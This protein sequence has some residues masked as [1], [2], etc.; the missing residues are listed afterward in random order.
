MEVIYTDG[1][2]EEENGQRMGFESPLDQTPDRGENKRGVISESLKEVDGASEPKESLV[3]IQTTN[4]EQN[5][6]GPN[7]LTFA[8]SMP[9]AYDN[10]SVD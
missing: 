3:N 7:G 5:D 9:V 4:L 1:G 6:S 8:G 10:A 2:N